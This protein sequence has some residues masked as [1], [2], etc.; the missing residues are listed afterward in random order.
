MGLSI[1]YSGTIKDYSLIEELVAEVEDIC[2]TLDWEYNVFT[3]KNLGNDTRHIENPDFINYTMEDLKGI[4]F[5]P[6]DCEPVILTFFPSGKLCSFL[7]L[8]YNN[9]R[10]NDLMVEVVSTKTQYAGLDAHMAVLNLLQYL[11]DKYFSVFEL[12]DEG[13][14]W[15][16]KDKKVLEENFSRYNFLMDTVAEA[17]SDFKP[18]PGETPTSLAERLEAFLKKIKIDNKKRQ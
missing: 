10:T 14:Y 16:T 5:A 7:K 18:V 12:S 1:H 11:K 2:K 9:P 13:N 6:K 8:M 17:L 3:K 4:S 15:A